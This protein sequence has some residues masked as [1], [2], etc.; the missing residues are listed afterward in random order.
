MEEFSEEDGYFTCAVSV[1]HKPPQPPLGLG[2]NKLTCSALSVGGQFVLLPGEP[3]GGA[4]HPGQ[5]KHDFETSI[6]P[7][8]GFRN[9]RHLMNMNLKRKQT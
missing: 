4:L 3:P 7:I 2:H 5:L 1:Q 8:N 6:S 9:P